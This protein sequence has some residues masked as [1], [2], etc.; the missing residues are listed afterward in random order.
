MTTIHSK[1]IITEDEK[2]RIKETAAKQKKSVTAFIRDCVLSCIPVGNEYKTVLALPGMYEDGN[3]PQRLKLRTKRMDVR[4]TDDEYEYLKKIAANLNFPDLSAFSRYV[5]LSMSGGRVSFPITTDDLNDLNEN[6]AEINMHIKGVIGGMR[7]RDD[8]YKDDIERLENL[9]EQV[10]DQVTKL[11]K[12]VY[13]NRYSIRKQGVRALERRLNQLFAKDQ[14]QAY[15]KE[16][17]S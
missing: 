4:F 2:R 8:I 14:K 3:I 9:L 5:L 7:F 11:N 13:D 17:P 1:L 12:H 6:V 16:K 10:N 15:D